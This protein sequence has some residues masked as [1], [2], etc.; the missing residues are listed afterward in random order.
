MDQSKL[1]NLVNVSKPC[2]INSKNN[3]NKC[4]NFVFNLNLNNYNLKLI[5]LS[6]AI[7]NETHEIHEII[8]NSELYR[9]LNNLRIDIPTNKL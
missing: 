2:L 1:K 8:C 9:F 6:T 4:I 5:L 7:N 3:V